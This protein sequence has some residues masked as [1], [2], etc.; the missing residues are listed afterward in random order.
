MNLEDWL[1]ALICLGI[2]VGGSFGLWMMG[3]VARKAMKAIL[4]TFKYY[5]TESDMQVIG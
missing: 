2:V 3:V 5:P 1:M 4:D